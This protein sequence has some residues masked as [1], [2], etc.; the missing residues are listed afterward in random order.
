MKTLKGLN[1][2]KMVAAGNDFILFKEGDFPPDKDAIVSLCHRQYGVGADGILIVGRDSM[3]IFNSDG[4]EAEMCGNGARCAM[5]FIFEEFGL[6]ETLMNTLAGH[7]KGWFYPETNRA[8]VELTQPKDVKRG[9]SIEIDS[10]LL[11]LDFANTGVPHAVVFTDDI[12]NADVV[13]VGRQIRYHQEFAPAGANVNF[14]KINSPSEIVVRTYERGV[15][16]ETLA[17]GTGSV[18]SAFLSLLNQDLEE[19]NVNVLTRSGEVLSVEVK[20]QGGDIKTTLEG[21][22]KR[23]FNG[24]IFD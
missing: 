6:K 9:L 19:G 23:V 5:R 14:V 17:C 13:S 11:S 1:I 15:E 2:V 24:V 21:P 3:R 4:S 22:V 7:V 16:N 10:G 12:E 18:A 20:K 8:K